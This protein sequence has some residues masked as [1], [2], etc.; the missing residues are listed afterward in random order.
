MS[1]NKVDEN[2]DHKMKDKVNAPI[3]ANL[4]LNLY[5]KVKK[6]V[7]KLFFRASE[8]CFIY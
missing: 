6:F 1:S 8:F 3:C 4:R 5:L 7:V 2:I